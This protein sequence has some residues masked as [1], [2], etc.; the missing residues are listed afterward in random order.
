MFINDS[1]MTVYPVHAERYNPRIQRVIPIP[2]EGQRGWARL[3]RY[4]P[5]EAVSYGGRRQAI[6]YVQYDWVPFQVHD[7]SHLLPLPGRVVITHPDDIV[8]PAP[9]GDAPGFSPTLDSVTD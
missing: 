6:H 2:P 1:R 7:L 4:E 3:C 9:P 5:G 8:P